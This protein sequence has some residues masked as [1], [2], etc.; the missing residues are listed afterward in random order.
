MNFLPPLLHVTG[1]HF[2][3][4]TFQ[5]CHRK[6]RYPLNFTLW[7][8]NFYFQIPKLSLSPFQFCIDAPGGGRRWWTGKPSRLSEHSR[9]YSM[10]DSQSLGLVFRTCS[11]L[12]FVISGFCTRLGPRERNTNIKE[13]NH[14]P[15]MASLMPR[16]HNTKP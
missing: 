12:P 14:R 10:W 8:Y 1:F 9:C 7:K 4:S 3:L 15:K 16:A 6:R 5:R 2:W 13:K 11:T